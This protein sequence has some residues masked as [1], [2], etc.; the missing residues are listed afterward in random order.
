MIKLNPVYTQAK[1]SI[2]TFYVTYRI[3]NGLYAHLKTISMALPMNFI[4]P[5]LTIHGVA[6]F[7]L[8]NIADVT[9]MEIFERNPN[10]S[11]TKTFIYNRGKDNKWI[12]E[13]SHDVTFL[14]T[15]VSSDKCKWA[16][17]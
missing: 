2:T 4:P 6:K 15:C 7:L 16:D 9:C 12:Y 14:L 1:E 11:N 13:G 17:Y 10:S 5:L 8:E 3:H